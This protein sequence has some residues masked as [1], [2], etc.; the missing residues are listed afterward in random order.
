M[1]T[2]TEEWRNKLGRF[3]MNIAL[4]FGG[5]NYR[6]ELILDFWYWLDEDLHPSDAHKI[7]HKYDDYKSLNK[8]K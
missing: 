2:Y 3:I 5:I 6:R 4:K 1:Q 8:K 7:L